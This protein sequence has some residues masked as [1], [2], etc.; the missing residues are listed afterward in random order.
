METTK[1]LS[2][3]EWINKMWYRQRTKDI[4]S[5]TKMNEILIHATW[6]NLE[7]MLNEISL[8]EKDKYC[9]IPLIRYLE[10]ANS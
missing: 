10:L 2:R 4:H 1:T 6:M 5:A 3:D 7:S 8:T 9:M